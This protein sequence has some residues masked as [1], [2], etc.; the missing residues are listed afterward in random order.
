MYEAEL[1]QSPGSWPAATATTLVT[2]TTVTKNA[3]R[4]SNLVAGRLDA[5]CFAE[6]FEEQG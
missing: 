6:A 2:P 3:A 4:M 1:T 5:G